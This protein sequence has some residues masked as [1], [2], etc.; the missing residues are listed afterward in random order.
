MLG[1][2]DP[3][4]LYRI[5]GTIDPD[6]QHRGPLLETPLTIPKNV[7]S[8]KAFPEAPQ[9]A[10]VTWKVYNNRVVPIVSSAVL[11]GM[12]QSF[13]NFQ[14]TSTDLYVRGIKPTCPGTFKTDVANNT[15][16]SVSGSSRTCSPA[17]TPRYHP[18]SVR[19]AS[20]RFSTSCCPTPRCGRRPR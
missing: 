2:T 16:P 14:N 1:P 7:Y 18:R 20:S 12:L 15:L 4:R 8:W 17:S 13:K 6:G 9:D 5:S 19:R 3:N 11:D 10:G